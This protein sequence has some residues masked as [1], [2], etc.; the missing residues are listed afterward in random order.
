MGH[1]TTQTAAPTL[2]DLEAME[3]GDKDF[4][5]EESE[6]LLSYK[7]NDPITRLVNKVH[8][9]SHRAGLI[10]IMILL[11]PIVPITSFLVGVSDMSIALLVR[12]WINL[13]DPLFVRM[14]WKTAVFYTVIS[15]CTILMTGFLIVGDM[16]RRN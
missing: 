15:G 9:W 5:W 6:K 11:L 1:Y 10:V 16:N 14:N 2:I 12:P 13:L 4:D 8:F 7:P 3:R